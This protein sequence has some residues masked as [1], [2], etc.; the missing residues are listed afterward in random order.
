MSFNVGGCDFC[1][2]RD[3][4]SPEEAYRPWCRLITSV[5]LTCD[6]CRDYEQLED[7]INQLLEKR[8]QLKACISLYH[9]KEI[10][11]K[12]PPEVLANIFQF[13]VSSDCESHCNPLFLGA[14]CRRWRAIAWSAPRLWCSIAINVNRG[15]HGDEVRLIR[16]WLSRSGQLPLSIR[17]TMNPNY[18]LLPEAV[19]SAVIEG[20]NEYADRWRV[21]DIQVPP[22]MLPL[23]HT[24]LRGKSILHTLTIDPGTC[25]S[26]ERISEIFNPMNPRPSP[27]V[28]K[29]ISVNL[30]SIGISWYKVTH[31]DLTHFSV[32]ECF[33]VLRQAPFLT[34]G[35]FSI[36]PNPNQFQLPEHIIS[37][38]NLTSLHFSSSLGT[39]FF[40]HVSFPSLRFLSVNN[41][42]A[43]IPAREILSFLRR[44][45]PAL[46]ELHL[47]SFENDD[48][49]S[50]IQILNETPSLEILH[51]HPGFLDDST[52]TRLL[53]RL[54]DSSLTLNDHG[55]KFLPRLNTISYTGPLNFPWS[56][57]PNL[58][59]PTWRPLSNFRLRC[60]GLFEGL[61]EGCVD[62]A[63][64]LR[65]QGLERRGISIEITDDDIGGDFLAFSRRRS[66]LPLDWDDFFDV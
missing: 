64:L 37:H 18:E 47:L 13:F 28:V 58:F 55:T 36:L 30:R 15:S 33:E 66:S 20:V 21:L 41:C 29:I 42:Y 11:Q 25:L 31:L 27:T 61:E 65:I 8:H 53:Q 9:R 17:I 32:D 44:S 16:D 3:T 49:Q 24:D 26:L 7:Q 50:V 14:I 10:M 63:T 46:N 57:I 56:A 52:P 45:S 12:I 19:I 59:G 40:Q 62:E 38:P 23:F 22:S 2:S 34:N 48:S 54:S 39:I 43:Q 5:A 6:M 51:L 1:G 60:P 35:S 4:P